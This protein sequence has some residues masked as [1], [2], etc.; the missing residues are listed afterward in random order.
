MR[1]GFRR[2]I[3]WNKYKSKISRKRPNEYFDY[4]IDPSFQG[5]NRLF[6]LKF[7]NNV[8]RTRHTVYLLP[9]IKIKD[10]NVMIDGKNFFDQPVKSN[11]RTY[12]SIRKNATGQ[13]DDYTTVCLLDSPYFKESYKLIAIDLRKQQTLDVD[14]KAI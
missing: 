10:Y 4:L 1:S 6:A 7:E 13:G 5:V 14:P 12:D 8:H 11:L 3:N 9:K 2:T